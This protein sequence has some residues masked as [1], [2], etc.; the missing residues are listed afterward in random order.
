MA[1][2]LVTGASGFIGTHLVPKLRAN[3]HDVIEVNSARGDLSEKA[4]WSSLPLSEVVIH[5]A[6]KTFVPD[7]WKDP[8]G[9]LK[10]NLHGTVGALNYCRQ[11]NARLVFLSSYLY[12]NPEKLP[13]QE[14]ASLNA[15]N[16]YALSKKLAEEA[17]EFY[18]NH[19]GIKTAILRPF[20]VY[21]PGQAESFLIP[22]IVNQVTSGDII[23]VKDLEPKRDYIYID[24][25]IDAITKTVDLNR[26]FNIFNIGTGVSHSVAE[27]INLIQEI[28]GTNRVVHSACERR[29]EEVM[30]AKADITKVS[31]VLGWV[32]KWSLRSGLQK[33]LSEDQCLLKTER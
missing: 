2:V 25:L 11:Y 17:C 26:K 23:R 28:K 33:I 24:D 6:G 4:T 20:N 21:G 14:S 30:D 32:P 27:I 29:P 9:F 5:L 7:S 8:A 15:N 31:E 22:S 18:A 13:I 12:G 16:P 19:F 1:K 10:T 3:R